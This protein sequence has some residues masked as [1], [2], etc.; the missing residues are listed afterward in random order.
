MTAVEK[1]GDFLHSKE[2]YAKLSKYQ[3]NTF[4]YI[5]PA[6]LRAA[7]KLFTPSFIKLH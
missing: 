3:Q 5:V 6:I 4:P 2:G 1:K 7:S